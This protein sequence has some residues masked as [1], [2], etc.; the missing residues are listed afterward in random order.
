MT[1]ARPIGVNPM[2]SVPVSLH[3]KCSH[4]D[5]WRGLNNDI[6]VLV[7]GSTPS[8][9]LDLKLLHHAQESQRLFSSELP[10]FDTGMMCSISAIQNL[11]TR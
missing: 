2:I 3:L 5:W 4:H 10:C 6:C 11:K 7:T 9:L 8:I 1:V